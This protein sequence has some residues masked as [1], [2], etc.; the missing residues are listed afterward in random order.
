MVQ[1]ETTK[2]IVLSVCWGMAEWGLGDLVFQVI[3]EDRA[4]SPTPSQGIVLIKKNVDKI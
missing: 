1:T 3:F 2:L 4:F